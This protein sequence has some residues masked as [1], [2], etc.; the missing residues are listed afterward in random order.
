MVD[1]N[2]EEAKTTL[3]ISLD[4]LY[5]LYF[6]N[7]DSKFKEKQNIQKDIFR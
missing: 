1:V 3:V 4:D 7:S 5:L 6:K 2:F